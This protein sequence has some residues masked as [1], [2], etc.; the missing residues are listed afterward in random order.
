VATINAKTTERTSSDL[1][2][3]AEWFCWSSMSLVVRTNRTSETAMMA[4]PTN[5]C[6]ADRS[7]LSHQSWIAIKG[8]CFSLSS[9]NDLPHPLTR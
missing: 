5:E 4:M 1:T 2:L 3:L 7:D 8:G 9:P 6:S